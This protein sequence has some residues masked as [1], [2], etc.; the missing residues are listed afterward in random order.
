MESRT[1]TG[2]LHDILTQPEALS[3]THNHLAQAFDLGT[4]PNQIKAGK[5]QRIILTGMGSS[6]FVFYPLYFDLMKQNIPVTLIETGEL[7]HFAPELIAK[8]SL[9][10]TAS[11]SGNSAETVRLLQMNSTLGATVLGITNTADSALAK[12]ANV[13]LLSKA[14]VEATVSCKTYLST[15][16]VLRWLQNGLIGRDLNEAN[17]ETTLV[18]EL[19]QVYLEQWKEHVSFLKSE[20][21]DQ[22]NFF[23]CG[24]GPSMA[25]VL[26]GSL[27]AK[28]STLMHVEGLSCPALRHG[29]KEMMLKSTF[30]MMF[31]GPEKTRS[32]NQALKKELSAQGARVAWVSADTEIPAYRL[33][34]CPSGLLPVFESLPTQMFNLALADLHHH[35]AGTFERATKITV[36]E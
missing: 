32:L 23:M 7:I 30:V 28:E 1:Q 17:L 25:A 21:E 12:G 11:Q 20:L 35:V 29:P 3:A 15:L 34:F 14:G 24:R 16:L 26:T 27:T 36:I 13:T 10:I 6:H 9:L 2:Y 8:D 31:E 5:F 19:V 4:I 18:S 33:P 22:N